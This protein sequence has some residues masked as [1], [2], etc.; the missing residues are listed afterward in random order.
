M[1]L[2]EPLKGKD[3]LPAGT[4]VAIIVASAMKPTKSGSGEY[5]ELEYQIIDGEHK[6]RKL[7]SRHNLHHPNAQTVQIARSELS[8]ICHAVG[9]MTPADSAE[10]HNL[11]LTLSV[12]CRK[13]EDNGE[14]TNEVKAWGRKEAAS[15]VPQQAAPTGNAPA[16]WLRRAAGGAP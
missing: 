14:V 2:V 9:I 5:L 12:K 7:W 16:P 6:G 4:Y 13:R 11:P 15:G 8:S 1:P 10:F 3:A